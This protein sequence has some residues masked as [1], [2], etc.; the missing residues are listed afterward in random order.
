MIARCAVNEMTNP[1]ADVSG[2]D[3]PTNSRLRE[4]NVSAKIVSSRP[5]A[6]MDLTPSSRAT[7][8]IP[9]H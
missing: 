5:R 7:F 4:R 8:E 3:V 9:F 2:K 1:I 6:P